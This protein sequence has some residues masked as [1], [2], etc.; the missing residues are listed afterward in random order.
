MTEWGIFSDESADWTADQA[1]EAQMYSREEAEQRLAEIRKEN[2][3]DADEDDN[4]VVHM[5][6]EPDDEEEDDES[7]EGDTEEDE[8]GE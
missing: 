6:E 4:C 5:V 8:D 3:V 7:D 2:G 1:I